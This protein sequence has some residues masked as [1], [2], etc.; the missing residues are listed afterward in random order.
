ME[1]HI[2]TLWVP[3]YWSFET[4]DVVYLHYDQTTLASCLCDSYTT[5]LR[6]RK[7]QYCHTQKSK[8]FDHNHEMSDAAR[9][10]KPIQ[11]LN[12]VFLD[13]VHRL[14]LK[15]YNASIFSWKG[16]KAPT[17]LRSTDNCSQSL[18]PV[19]EQLFL[20]GSTQCFPTISP[21]DNS[22]N[23]FRNVVLSSDSLFATTSLKLVITI[24]SHALARHYSFD[25][26]YSVLR[27]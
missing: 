3:Q 5:T 22:R 25:S 13:S 23:I 10:I 26:H 7:L 1:S 8:L 19:T 11:A 2:H 15:K 9:R 24:N 6:P 20:S 18:G 21:D 12:K 14:M 16:G 27:Q 4:V 17:V